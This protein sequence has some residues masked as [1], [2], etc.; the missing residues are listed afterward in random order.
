VTS[1]C[2]LWH[3]HQPDYRLPGERDGLL[4]WVRLHAVR[5]YNDLL[6][7]LERHPSM[8]SCVNFSGILLEQI[9]AAVDGAS[10]RYA[11]L[12]A[13]TVDTLE[14]QEREHIVRHFFSANAATLIRP[15]RRYWE[16]YNRREEA[17]KAGP[18]TPLAGIFTDDELADLMVWFN[19]A[20]IGFDGQLV[21]EVRALIM[22]GRGF[23][24]E[25]QL[26]V[27]AVH[28]KLIRKI[29][30]GYAE[31]A[32]QGVVELS[33]TP[34]YHPILPLLCDLSGMGRSNDAD[35]LPEF[36]HADDAREQIRRGMA[37]FEHAFGMKPAGAWPA[38]GSVSDEALSLL[39]EEGL[40]WA[41]TDQQ[42]LP[43]GHGSAAHAIP[44][45]WQRDG[46]E[47]AVFFRDTRLADN[48][49]FDYRN[50]N[51]GQAARHLFDMVLGLSRQT[52]HPH[53]VITIALDGENPWEHYNGGG[54]G[55]LNALGERIAS[56]HDISCIT[57]TTA[58]QLLRADGGMPPMATI[59]PGSWIGGNFD[60]WSRHAET[61]VAWR[62]LTQAREDLGDISSPEVRALLLRAE[63]SDSFW[64]YG[65]DF[66]SDSN[67]QFDLLFRMTLIAAYET[68]DRPVPSNLYEPICSAFRVAGALEPASV[69]HPMLDGRATTFF[70]WLGSVEIPLWAGQGSMAKSSSHALREFRYGFSE[71][72][73]YIR[74]D[75]NGGW[76]DTWREIGGQVRVCLTQGELELCVPFNIP[77]NYQPGNIDESMGLDTILELRLSVRPLGLERGSTAH[78]WLELAAPGTEAARF[79]QAGRV[80]IRIPSS[81]FAVRSWVV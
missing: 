69:I 38:E 33:F 30:P 60:I 7:T 59:K 20:W 37:Q 34:H 27:L 56:S 68:A 16:L 21:P 15:H 67:E 2:F 11:T 75:L 47:L 46:R 58:I 32:R 1:V 25:D 54:E 13:K 4:P 29:L 57:P 39:A 14:P 18:D 80:P 41:A 42:N 12:S 26:Q 79:P 49:G 77:A 19:L 31:L 22:K 65:D 52:T 73:L 6:A 45:I 17:L 78:F 36:H 62:R 23:R 71:E 3:F 51:P 53:P 66:V 10:D 9:C 43:G 55:F 8:R 48:I 5:G 40:S 35:P 63:G 64:W 24:H 74:L 81:D 76:K 72:A 44:W 28:Q 70:E 50:W 61:R